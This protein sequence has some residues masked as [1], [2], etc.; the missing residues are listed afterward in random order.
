MFQL[1]A[2]LLLAAFLFLVYIGSVVF[3]AYILSLLWNIWAYIMDID[4]PRADLLWIII[5]LLIFELY[6]FIFPYR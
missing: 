5:A 1:I 2:H 6:K 4:L 3:Q